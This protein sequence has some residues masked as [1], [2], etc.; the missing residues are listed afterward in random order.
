MAFNKS[1]GK[2]K[3]I[4]GIVRRF[5]GFRGEALRSA[6]LISIHR[7]RQTPIAKRRLRALQCDLQMM[8]KWRGS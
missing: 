7:E 5:W 2:M 8:T 4:E 3:L 6:P 1:E